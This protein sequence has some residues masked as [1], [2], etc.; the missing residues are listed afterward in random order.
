M[1][2]ASRED[3]DSALLRVRGKSCVAASV[4]PPFQAARWADVELLAQEL[5]VAGFVGVSLGERGA[6][7]ALLSALADRVAGAGAFRPRRIGFRPLPGDM[8]R[9]EAYR[10]ARR[11]VIFLGPCSR[12]VILSALEAATQGLGPGGFVEV[13]LK[14]WDI[15]RDWQTGRERVDDIINYL[16]QSKRCGCA[17][18]LFSDLLE[19]DAGLWEFIYQRPR[20]RVAWV[21]R[22]LMECGSMRDFQERRQQS[23][24]L[25][26][27]ERL[28]EAGVWPH[29]VLPVCQDNCRA[30]PDLVLG[31]IEVTRGASIDLVPAPM[32][33]GVKIPRH[34]TAKADAKEGASRAG[35]A[36]FPPARET[37]A[38]DGDEAVPAPSVEDYVEALMGICRNPRVP[39]RLVSP[40]SWVAARID[41]QGTMVS[42]RAGAG[43]ELAVLPD[44]DVYAGESVVGVDQWRLGNVL[45]DGADLRWERL[46]TISEMAAYSLKP[47]KCASCPWRY[48]CGGVDASVLLLE[49]RLGPKG[50]Q[51]GAALREFYCE[52]CRSLFEELLW[53]S[54]ETVA[55]G[56][57]AGGRERVGLRED[58][59]DFMAVENR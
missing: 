31:L 7:R 59:V 50:E 5:R 15:L 14:R 23:A 22:D 3:F 54:M 11:S 2:D 42:S 43:A 1:S 26:N 56:Q 10:Q 6:Q 45:A 55:R 53:T 17:L 19:V 41:A 25:G 33:D 34:P 58:G 9:L 30:V 18:T 32:L 40:L 49:E 28:G 51:G 20:V 16:Y 57:S 35:N 29:V 4:A 37:A 38:G 27:L 46:D 48:R 47:A 39:L 21:A 36:S 12:E 8:A 44:G 13:N 24:A 52:A